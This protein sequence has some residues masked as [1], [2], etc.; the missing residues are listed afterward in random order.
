MPLFVLVWIYVRMYRAAKSNINKTRRHSL[1][2]N[3]HEIIIPDCPSTPDSG[4]HNSVRAHRQKLAR[5]RSSNTSLFFRE[6]GR[7]VKPR[8]CAG[9][10]VILQCFIYRY[11]S[12]F[13]LFS[14]LLSLFL[15]CKDINGEE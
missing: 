9:A 6:E 2:T 13:N 11:I 12:L 3:P 4:N 8:F 5:R 15:I 1:G 10:H 14:H 7:A